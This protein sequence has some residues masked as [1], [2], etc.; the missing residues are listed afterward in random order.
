MADIAILAAGHGDR[1]VYATNA[2][3]QV[4]YILGHSGARACFVENVE[5]ARQG[6]AL[7]IA[8]CPSSSTS[9]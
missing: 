7:A 6:S 1:P 3:S 9:S 5:Q 4:G 8:S 2:A